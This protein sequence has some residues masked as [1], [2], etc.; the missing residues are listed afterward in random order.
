MQTLDANIFDVL[1]I[2]AGISGI[3]CACHLTRELPGKTWAILEAREDLGGTWDL[4]KYPG[5]RS[6][7][8]LHTF[9]YEFKPWPSPNAIASGDEIMAYL[10]ETADEYGVTD[11]IHYSHR[12]VSA[13][14]DSQEGLWTLGVQTPSGLIRAK[15]RWVF[16][17][18]GYYDYE[19]A[20]RPDFPGEDAFNG[21]VIH[22]QFWPEGYDYT[23][24][25]VAVIGS[26]ATAITLIPAMADKA[27][28]ITQVQRTPSYV[29]PRPK[30]D[31]LAKLLKS[32]LPPKLAHSA[33]RWKNTRVQRYFYLYCQR[34]P[35]RARNL[36]RKLNE[37]RLPEDYPVDVHFNPPYNPWDQR[38]CASPDGDFFD[39]LKSGKASVFT[40]K[41][42]QFEPN[43][44][45][46]TSGDF[47]EA[48]TVIV[49]T[50]LKLKMLG[51]I[52]LHVDGEPV[53]VPSAFVFRGMMLS[54]VPNFAFSIGYTNSSWTLKV[55]ILCKY[56]C[57]LLG[58]MDAE[59]KTKCV[60]KAPDGGMEARP[61][62]DFSA[63]YVQRAINEL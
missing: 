35:D 52:P 29:M 12:V 16:S 17:A 22:P 14:W 5:I 56:L 44:L 33:T 58:V 40:G 27:A 43:G 19:E 1:I 63:G 57:K 15:C 48:D 9:S 42:D 6:D 61:L 28:H 54:G 53:D 47:I 51:G 55:D 49:A 20:F 10:R 38:L 62:L 59:G 25:R 30:Q 45:R 4:F 60:A 32:V 34:F 41:I 3:G 26:G 23:G 18:T 2:G 36:I 11:A 13:D 24:K 8:D 37:K 50:G 7:S 46:M 39:V 31:R 21:E